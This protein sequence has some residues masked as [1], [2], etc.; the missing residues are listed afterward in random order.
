MGHNRSIERGTP[1]KNQHAYPL[2]EKYRILKQ[3]EKNGFNY[4]MTAE[5]VNLSRVTLHKWRN[6]HPEAFKNN[7]KE[8]YLQ[9]TEAVIAKENKNMVEV[10]G[11]V[12]RSALKRA[13]TLLAEETNLDK[14]SNFIKAITPLVEALR[15]ETGARK[16][17][18]VI[19][20]TFR[21]LAQLNGGNAP[22]IVDVESEDITR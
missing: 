2:V 15:G 13:N 16:E 5:Q 3:L 9:E 21:K 7:F 1:T 8:R 4:T 11:D 18:G 10:A 14:V 12:V 17:L 6:L 19:Q 22:E 20:E